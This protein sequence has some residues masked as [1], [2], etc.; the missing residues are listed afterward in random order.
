MQKR[1]KIGLAAV[2]FAA[3][4]FA[5]ISGQGLSPA[6]AQTDS[7]SDGQ[8]KAIEKIVKDYLV[9]HPEVLLEAQEA[10]DKKQ[11]TLRAEAVKTR[12]PGFYKALADLAPQL[13]SMTVG[14]GDVTIVEFF[15]YNCGYCRKTLPDLV[16]LLENDHN[17]KVQFI[18]YPDSC[19]E[20]GGSGQSWHRRREAGQ[21][22]G[23]P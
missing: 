21:I 16:K 9:N 19:G 18:E 4:G 5:A 17:V 7:F 8:V 6:A 15:D 20:I 22:L 10:L 13:S 12:L 14:S 3:L 23:I 2:T 1:M 11:E